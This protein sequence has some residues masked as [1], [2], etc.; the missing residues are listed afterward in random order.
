MKTS[1]KGL[2]WTTISVFV[3][4]S[5]ILAGCATPTPQTI[6]VKETVPVKVTEIIKETSVVIQAA[7]TTVPKYNQNVKG[8]VEI[9]HWWA[10]PVRRNAIKRILA[11]CMVELPNIKIVDVVKP[12][13]DIWT[14]NIAAVAAGS[15]M[16]DIIVE[17]RPKLPQ[18][19]KDGVVTNL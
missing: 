11:T 2:I 19:G 5:M 12:W 18:T 8:E 3:V 7:P 17:D 10:S 6:I 15:G 9:W 14:A 16:P 13:G 1:S 4:L